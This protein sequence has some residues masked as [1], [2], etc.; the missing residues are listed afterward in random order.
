VELVLCRDVYHCRP[1]ELD[2][3]DADVVLTHLA[4]LST[5]A[6]VEEFRAKKHRA[7][8]GK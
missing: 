7:T 8:R 5:A 3:E 1:S 6:K 4:L 2:G